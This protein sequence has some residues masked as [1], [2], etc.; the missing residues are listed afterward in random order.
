MTS[1]KTF[2]PNVV[3]RTCVFHIFANFRK[4]MDKVGLKERTKTIKNCFLTIQGMIFLDFSDAWILAWAKELILAM[5]DTVAQFVSNVSHVQKWKQF[6]TYL[7]RNWLN[8]QNIHFIG[9]HSNFHDELLFNESPQITNNPS[10]SL[11]R[12][13]KGNY[14]AGRISRNDLASGIHE[15]FHARRIKLQVFLNGQKNQSRSLCDIRRW[16]KQQYLAQYVQSVLA[17]SVDHN[18]RSQVLYKAAYK[19][20]RIYEPNINQ[21]FTD[22]HPTIHSYIILPIF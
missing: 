20:G 4:K 17:N 13:L 21:I 15:F 2:F 16:K 7:L 22:S 11:N 3:I 10:E 1:A 5:D 6:T 14:D 9:A 19:H 8:P 18:L 12:I